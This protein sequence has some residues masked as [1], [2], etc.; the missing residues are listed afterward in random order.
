M[1][2]WAARVKVAE[3]GT[4]AC[5][6]RQAE[7]FRRLPLGLHRDARDRTPNRRGQPPSLVR[8]RLEDGD[9][10][11]RGS[12]D[13]IR[14]EHVTPLTLTARTAL[15]QAQRDVA[16]SATPGSSRPPP[17]PSTRSPGISCGIGGCGG[18]SARSWTQ[19]RSRVAQPP[20][21]V[22]HGAEEDPPG[23]SLRARRVGRAADGLEVLST[24]GPGDNACSAGP[25]A[26]AQLGHERTHQRTHRPLS[27][28]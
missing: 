2:K 13:K 28:Q 16:S 22:C 11:G 21:K 9:G 20:A 1:A 17:I 19:S 18:S 14:Y 8:H 12:Q 4:L 5:S 25:A 26:T 27:P 15:E 10:Q 3:A 23:R 6:W 24:A 7:L